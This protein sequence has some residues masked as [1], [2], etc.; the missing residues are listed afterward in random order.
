MVLA[1]RK[2]INLKQRNLFL[3]FSKIEKVSSGFS[4]GNPIGTHADFKSLSKMYLTMLRAMS[5]N[6]LFL[7][8]KVMYHIALAINAT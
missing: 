2:I 5:T 4:T 7:P 8:H 6:S 1:W 3:V